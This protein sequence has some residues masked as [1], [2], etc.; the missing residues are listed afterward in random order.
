METS[1]IVTRLLI[2]GYVIV[3]QVIEGA[4]I[5]AMRNAFE[6]LAARVGKRS[7]TPEEILTEPTLL[8]FIAPPRLM[9]VL[10][11]FFAHHGHEPAVAWL[12]LCRDIFDPEAP[13][14]PPFDVARDGKRIWLH[15]D[16]SPGR[17]PL[18]FDVLNQG[19]ATFLFMDDAEPDAGCLVQAP[20]THHLSRPAPDGSVISPHRQFIRDHCDYVFPRIRAG[21]VLIQRAFNFHA[22][23]PPPRRHRRTIRADYT[24]KALFHRMLLDGRRS[25]PGVHEEFPEHAIASLPVERHRVFVT[26]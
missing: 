3:P 9:P 22:P 10:D 2:E 21:D 4:E 16:G 13:P 24:P 5:E 19:C 25:L 26:A 12:L 11:A 6:S 1:E 18:A 23:G 14:P 17:V 20:G 15:N 7:F 8:R